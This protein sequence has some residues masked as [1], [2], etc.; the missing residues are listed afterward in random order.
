MPVPRRYAIGNGRERG[1]RERIEA[2]CGGERARRRVVYAMVMRRRID[3][4]CR[5][6]GG[7]IGDQRRYP[8]RGG[9]MYSCGMEMLLTGLGWGG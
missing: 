9:A 8:G 3:R 6:V 7:S 4:A 5:G 2:W 1:W